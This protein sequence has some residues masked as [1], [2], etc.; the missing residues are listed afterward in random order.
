M[1]S[2]TV[3]LPSSLNGHLRIYN[4]FDCKV[5]ISDSSIGNFSIE[6]FDAFH[7]NYNPRVHKTDVLSVNVDPMCQF[8]TNTS[9]KNIS[10]IKGNVSNT[11]TFLN[12]Y[13][14]YTTYILTLIYLT[15]KVSSY[16]L[17]YSNN[18]GIEIKYLNKLNKLRNRNP[19]LRLV[20]FLICVHS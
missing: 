6:P 10:I 14:T 16:L 2:E 8:Q 13:N 20:V 9:N 19:N 17:T 11:I 12:F 5:I 18:K 7:I 4:N 3:T 15:I 1:Q